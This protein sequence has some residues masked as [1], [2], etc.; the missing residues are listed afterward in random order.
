MRQEGSL[1]ETGCNSRC[2]YRGLREWNKPVPGA[3]LFSLAALWKWGCSTEESWYNDEAVLLEVR[4]CPLGAG[5]SALVPAG[6]IGPFYPYHYTIEKE[7]KQEGVRSTECQKQ[8]KRG[9]VPA[10]WPRWG[11]FKKPMAFI[12]HRML[13][14][15]ATRAAIP[16]IRRFAGCWRRIGI[17]EVE[18]Y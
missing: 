16:G 5:G 1:Q 18:S 9:N 2:H 10:G 14:L 15:T 11:R 6:G 3:P 12:M 13:S 4:V 8:Y 7:K 17:G